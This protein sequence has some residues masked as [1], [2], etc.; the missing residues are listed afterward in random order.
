MTTATAASA[1]ASAAATADLNALLRQPARGSLRKSLVQYEYDARRRGE[2]AVAATIA[3]VLRE[4]HPDARGVDPWL[5]PYLAVPFLL[6]FYVRRWEFVMA[7]VFAWVVLE[8]TA[9]HALMKWRGVATNLLAVEHRTHSILVD[10]LVFVAGVAL[11]S[12]THAL[13]ELAPTREH[14]DATLLV[15]V[16]A[17]AVAAA[18]AGFR[19]LFFL[20][21]VAVCA[22]IA[23][24][25]YAD[26]ASTPEIG[27]THL[28]AAAA[29]SAFYAWFAAP[30]H[31]MY[32]YNAA[33]AVA[34]YAF[35]VSAL[36]GFAL[37][38]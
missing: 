9:W 33:Y 25:Y 37:A 10:T 7:A 20:S 19:R 14:V 8:A 27:H 12:Y 23:L 38:Q 29:V 2:T 6:Q 34:Y 4:E 13:F 15:E 3:Y 30:V 16:G 35:A 17:L 21:Y 31:S 11:A 22:T 5:L 1:S 36:Y 28:T 32:L 18:L 24:V 26:G